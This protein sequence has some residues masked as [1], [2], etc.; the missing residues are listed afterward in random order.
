M[1][2]FLTDLAVF[3]YNIATFRF[4]NESWFLFALLGLPIVLF[5]VFSWFYLMQWIW[6]RFSY[7]LRVWIIFVLLTMLW[8]GDKTLIII[9]FPILLIYLLIKRGKIKYPNRNLIKIS[10]SVILILQMPLLISKNYI[11]LKC[12]NKKEPHL[13]ILDKNISIEDLTLNGTI[14]KPIGKTVY[15]SGRDYP[16]RYKTTKISKTPYGKRHVNVYLKSDGRLIAKYYDMLYSVSAIDFL[17]SQ[18]FVNY[19]IFDYGVRIRCG[20]YNIDEVILEKIYNI[21]FLRK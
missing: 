7:N 19:S 14:L 2:D 12:I 15:S 17:I 10:I 6:K 1:N 8:F 3:Y 9:G 5:Y 13:E 20:Y 11:M 21:V 18:M 4:L 16:V